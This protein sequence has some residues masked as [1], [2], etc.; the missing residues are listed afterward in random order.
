MAKTQISTRIDDTLKQRIDDYVDRHDV[1]HAGAQRELLARGIDYEEGRLVGERND[2]ACEQVIHTRNAVYISVGLILVGFAA[3]LHVL[4]ANL[5]SAAFMIVGWT[6]MLK[7]CSMSG[8]AWAE[9]VAEVLPHFKQPDPDMKIR[10][11]SDE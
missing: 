9:R 1:T 7:S 5:L 10:R 2:D 8:D 4:S 11:Q 6:A 3:V